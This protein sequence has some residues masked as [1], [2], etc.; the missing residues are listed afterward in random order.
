VDTC[1]PLI[2]VVA[3]TLV[4]ADGK[5]GQGTGRWARNPQSGHIIPVPNAS[6][7]GTVPCLTTSG[8]A[9]SGF[10]DETGLIPV[11]A[12]PI[13]ANEGRIWSHEGSHNF[14]LHNVVA[15]CLTSNYGKHMAVR[16][17]T[18]RECERLQGFP[19]DYTLIPAW[20]RPARERGAEAQALYAYYCRTPEGR[21]AVEF[22]D[23]RVWATPDGPR[24]RALGNAMAVPVVRWLICRILA[25]N[26][27]LVG[28]TA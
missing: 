5:H 11:L 18:P 21:A 1:V 28:E 16:R 27:I 3:G 10:K 2:P 23:G 25:V 7:D 26:R 4:S 24:Y 9:H 8:D 15:P 14:R 17:L 20:R 12:D 13:S 19:D 6:G 22:R